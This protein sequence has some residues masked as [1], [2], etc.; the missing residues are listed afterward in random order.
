MIN[1]ELQTRYAPFGLLFKKSFI[2]DRG[3]RPV[4]YQP[5]S[6]YGI[7]PRE[8]QYRHVTFDL[9][10]VDF[11]WEREW[12]MQVDKIEFTDADIHVLVPSNTHA[13]NLFLQFSSSEPEFGYGVDG[14]EFVRDYLGHSAQYNLKVISLDILGL[15]DPWD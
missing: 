10:K 2:F 9:G 1:D 13:E 3:G 11:T 4:I 7:L 15:K 8:L 12:R 14:D 5:E 6:D